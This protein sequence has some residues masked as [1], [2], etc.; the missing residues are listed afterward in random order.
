[1]KKTVRLNFEFPRKYFPY[2][3]LLC[4]KKRQSL[5]DLASELL[6]REIE[7]YEDCQLA[8]KADRQ[9]SKMKN[10]DLIEF[11]DAARLSGWSDAE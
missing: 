5:K 10:K 11:N 6:I 1:M 2:L 8:K 4:A 7:E 3:K 9:F